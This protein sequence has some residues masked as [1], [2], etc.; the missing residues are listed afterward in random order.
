MITLNT[1]L[2][3]WPIPPLIFTQGVKKYLA[4]ETLWFRHEAT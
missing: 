2:E 3:I 1:D 4:F